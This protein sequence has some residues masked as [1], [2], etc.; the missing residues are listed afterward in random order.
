MQPKL[1]SI[2]V[3][4]YNEEE[5]IPLIYQALTAQFLKS[6]EK[7]DYEII[8]VNDGSKDK[9][10]EILENL[11]RQ[12]KKVKYIEFSR[13]FGK[14]IA[15]SAGLHHAKG[16][17][18]IMI[19]ADLQHPPE[20]IP[21]FL[22]KWEAGADTVIGIREESEKENAIRKISSM[23][24]YKILNAI[25]E[26][27]LVAGGTD[28][29]LIDRKMIDEFK[30]FTEHNRMTRGLLA[31]MGFKRDF[32][33]FKAK[34]RGNGGARYSGIKLVRLALYSFVSHSLFPLKLAGYLGVVIT[35]LSGILGL[36]IIFD[37][38]ILDDPWSFNFSGPA[39]LGV[40]TL[41]LVGIVLCCLGLIALYIANIHNEVT[42]RPMYVIRQKTNLK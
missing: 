16:H 40:F 1:I 31:W 8:F 42:N 9:G 13:N 11:A 41:F 38:Y 5:N 18:A 27:K 7:F 12:D 19:D 24:F 35:F 37:K 2:I 39:T 22:K 20:L 30:R 17:A 26:T 28:Y 15:T 3:P 34:A 29:R 32:I 4:V 23:L 21:E 10:A 14:E 36:F 6:K 25:G 33:R